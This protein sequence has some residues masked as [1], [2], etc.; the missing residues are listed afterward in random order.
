M[1][2]TSVL[3]IM[4][5]AQWSSPQAYFSAGPN[6]WSVCSSLKTVLPNFCSI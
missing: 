3:D 4:T 5:C 2:I 1:Y 6:S